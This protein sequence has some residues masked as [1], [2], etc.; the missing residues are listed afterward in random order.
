MS[1]VC[2]PLDTLAQH[3]SGQH[4]LLV[5]TQGFVKRGVAQRVKAILAPRQVTVW[6]GVKPNP[7]IKDLDAATTLL[8]P[9]GVDCVVGLGGGSALDVA[10]V[11]ATTIPNPAPPTLTNLFIDQSSTSWSRRLPLVAIPTTSGTGAEV[12]PF[13][14]V[15]DHDQK[16]KHSFAGS[17]VYPDF[18]L[19]DASLT[20]SLGSEDTLYPALDAISHSFESLWNKNRNPISKSL[21]MAS[22]LMSCEALPIVMR[23]PQNIQGRQ[24]L[25]NASLLA[26]MAIS[27]TRTAIAHSISYPLTTHFGIPHGLACSFTLPTLININKSTFFID[28]D[29][30]NIVENCTNFLNALD[31]PE[32]IKKYASKNIIL[33]L[34]SEINLNDRIKNYIGE[35]NA[36]IEDIVKASL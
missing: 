3:V 34:L 9:L 5:T 31:M 25:Q 30:K 6:D 33:D 23:D 10:K 24:D 11:L 1:I 8:K 35:E 7:D 36:S 20:L 2:A 15:W 14:T 13:A 32:L 22:L 17:F 29:C 28:E 26:G 27:N 4:V 21:A 16:K 18:A 12:T 19:L